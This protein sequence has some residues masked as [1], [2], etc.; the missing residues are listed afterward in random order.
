MTSCQ[1]SSRG[2]LLLVGA[3]ALAV[4]IL[5]LSVV[6]N[7]VLFTENVGTGED[8][9][10]S[11][12]ISEF[13]FE[14]QKDVRSLLLRINHANET[15]NTPELDESVHS[16]VA[17]YSD[18]MARMYASSGS[19]FVD[20]SYNQTLTTA[21]RIVQ[22]SDRNFTYSSSGATVSNW[23]FTNDRVDIGWFVVNVDLRNTSGEH[24]TIKVNGESEAISY[25]LNRSDGGNGADLRVQTTDSA[26]GA[27]TTTCESTGGRVLLDLRSGK[28]FAS[29]CTF[30]GVETLSPP[31]SVNVSN[32]DNI[33]GQY[34]LAVDTE[35]SNGSTD[36]Y[37]ACSPGDPG[38]CLSPIV[39]KGQ[40]D[41][42]YRSDQTDFTTTRNVSVYGS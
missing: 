8:R 11:S 29:E 26:G 14:S 20:V 2:Q 28:A 33:E 39:W 4:I 35:W 30:R 21:T 13:T 5:G 9:V 16:H 6:V 24:T 27:D 10:E 38:P 34:D 17:N 22:S 31:Y 42:T 7:T 40:V 36:D 3:V 25:Q 12:E 41:L 37:S 15:R 18:G 1:F 19:T 23:S 32:G